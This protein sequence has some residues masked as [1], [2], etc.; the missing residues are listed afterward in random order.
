MSVTNPV[1]VSFTAPTTYVDGTTMP[2]G[3]VTKYQYGFGTV[4]GAYT[5]VVDDADLTVTAGKQTGALPTNLAIGNWF[6]ASRSVTKDGATSGWSNEVPFVVAA[7]Q[8]SP[9]VD[10]GLA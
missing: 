10:F 6:S 2:A 8:P 9:I 4:S 7:K 1:T 5:L 3:E